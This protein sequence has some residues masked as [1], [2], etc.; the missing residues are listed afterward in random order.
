MVLIKCLQKARWI[1]CK[2]D[3][4]LKQIWPDCKYNIGWENDKRQSCI[5]YS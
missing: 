2:K 3:V 1:V 5:D 4:L